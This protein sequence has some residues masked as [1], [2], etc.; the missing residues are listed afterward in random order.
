MLDKLNTPTT[1]LLATMLFLWI[2]ITALHHK[3]GT[4]ESLTSKQI[5]ALDFIE[6]ITPKQSNTL[7][8]Q[9]IHALDVLAA[10]TP[11]QRDILGY[12]Q[13][14]ESIWNIPDNKILESRN[15]PEGE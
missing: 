13:A 7:T 6:S 10:L 4:S 3:D 12:I 8:P 5:H 2:S 1:A 15:I 9:Q 11:K 14:N